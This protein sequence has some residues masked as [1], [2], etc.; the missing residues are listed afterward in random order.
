MRPLSSPLRLTRPTESSFYSKTPPSSARDARLAWLLR[1]K[2]MQTFTPEL[3]KNG[4]LSGSR[5]ARPANNL[6]GGITM[7]R[8]N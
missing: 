7:G 8:S 2:N 1:R 6:G 4:V 3:S 5:I